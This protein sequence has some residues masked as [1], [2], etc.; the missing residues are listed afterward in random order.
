MKSL[1]PWIN[2]YT[3]APPKNREW[4]GYTSFDHR[5]KKWNDQHR[6]CIYVQKSISLQAV[7]Q[8][9]DGGQSL[10]ALDVSLP[11]SKVI[12]LINMYN[13]PRTFPAVETLRFWL[14][15]HNSR[16]TPYF[17]FMDAN[18]HHP[19]WNPLGLQSN[20]KQARDLLEIYGSRGFC[21]S[22]P[23]HMILRSTVLLENNGSDHQA[24]KLELAFQ[25][26]NGQ[27]QQTRPNWE[28]L[29]SETAVELHLNGLARPLSYISTALQG[30]QVTSQRPCKA[31]ELHLDGLE[32]PLS[33]ILA[34]LQGHQAT[35]QRPCKA[36]E[37][38][39][40]GLARPSSYISTALQGHQVTS[41]RPCKA[42]KLHL[43]GLSL[44]PSS[45][46]PTAMQGPRP[47]SYISTALQ[48]H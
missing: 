19:H 27:P 12:R 20:H 48:G 5:P 1:E 21:L 46:I 8:L 14:K 47:L 22:S 28:A 29:S 43:N 17:L 3:L 25:G 37:L 32:R 44:R 31:I 15:T 34:A 10:L 45:Y 39:L 33:Y 9:S 18:L 7:T 30:H 23:W 6:T 13:T 24:I 42:I 35:S 11:N 16:H 36:I 26:P 40:N 2:P 4:R 38:H 41:Q